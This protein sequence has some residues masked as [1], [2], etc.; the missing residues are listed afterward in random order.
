MRLKKLGPNLLPRNRLDRAALDLTHAALDFLS[1][2]CLNVYAGRSID[3]LDHHSCHSR[4]IAFSLTHASAWKH[5]DNFS[6]LHRCNRALDSGEH[7]KDV[8][9]AVANVDDNDGTDPNP[10]EVLLEAETLI[11]REDDRET[12]IDRRPKKHAVPQA[13]QP[14]PGE[15]WTVQTL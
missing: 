10:A 13:L 8:F 9:H 4:A 2:C 7:G 1:P 14:L 12:T 5:F 6:R 15:R 11:C 3:T